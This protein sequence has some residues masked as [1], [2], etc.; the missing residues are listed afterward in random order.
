MSLASQHLKRLLERFR[1]RAV[2]HR[3]EIVA[4]L[5]IVAML[6]IGPQLTPGP[7]FF[8]PARAFRSLP[9]KALRD[10]RDVTTNCQARHR[11]YRGGRMVGALLLAASALLVAPALAADDAT[12]ARETIIVEGNRRVEADTVRSY[13]HAWP[14]KQLDAA[15]LDAALNSLSATRLIDKLTIDRTAG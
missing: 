12:A 2:R 14:G 15:S 1:E 10:R 4:V 6:T 13:F 7:T 8:R 11:R 5:T 3:V 9:Y